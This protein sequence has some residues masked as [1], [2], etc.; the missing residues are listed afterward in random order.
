[1]K[2]KQVW[3]S[4]TAFARKDYSDSLGNFLIEMRAV[5]HRYLD[6]SLKLPE[7]LAFLDGELRKLMRHS[8]HRGKIDCMVQ[9]FPA[10]TSKVALKLNLPLAKTLYKA[11]AE[12]TQ[13]L[14]LKSEIR[15]GEILRWPQVL[16]PL[17]IEMNAIET[18]FMAHFSEA[19]NALILMREHEGGILVEMIAQKIQRLQEFMNRIENKLPDYRKRQQE[20][21]QEKIQQMTQIAIDKE[22]VEQEW[23]LF[24]QKTD[25]TEELERIKSHLGQIDLLFNEHLAIGRR[26]DFLTQELQ[27]EANTLT[28][29]AA[30]PEIT[31]AGIEMKILI[32][33]IREQAQN[34]E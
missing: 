28:S 15:V 23:V 7:S 4:M 20:K 18:Q 8:V 32:E 22:R 11:A 13:K 3:R 29:K 16:T 25:I 24:L 30:F 21:I 17:P 27:R 6:I 9:F 5:N 19:L 26:L 14:N 33:Q 34:I 2:T 1:M 12:L 31:Q 10:E